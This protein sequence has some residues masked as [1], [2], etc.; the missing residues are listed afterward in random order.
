MKCGNACFSVQKDKSVRVYNFDLRQKL[1][2]YVAYQ[3]V[4]KK[5]QKKESVRTSLKLPR[6]KNPVMNNTYSE[7]TNI[8]KTNKMIRTDSKKNSRWSISA[9]LCA[10]FSRSILSVSLRLI[11]DSGGQHDFGDNSPPF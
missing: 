9:P 1:S 6:D 5:I 2:S 11:D 10:V 8:E 3:S 7:K 4:F